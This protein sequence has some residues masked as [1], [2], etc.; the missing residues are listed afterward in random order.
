VDYHLARVH[1]GPLGD[2][3]HAIWDDGQSS[4]SASLW[5]K[6]Y[7]SWKGGRDFEIVTG[8]SRSVHHIRHCHYRRRNCHNPT[9]PELLTFPVAVAS[10]SLREKSQRSL[11]SELPKDAQQDGLYGRWIAAN[12]DESLLENGKMQHLTRCET[13]RSST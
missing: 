8:P 5:E 12:T 4:N 1:H 10:F 2:A 6:M 7:R 11:C 13:Y 9:T 3:R